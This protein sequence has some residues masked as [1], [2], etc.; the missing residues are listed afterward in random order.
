MPPEQL[1]PYLCAKWAKENGYYYSSTDDIFVKTAE[2]YGVSTPLADDNTKVLVTR[3][4]ANPVI[5][6]DNRK[7]AMPNPY[8]KRKY[9]PTAKQA[10]AVFLKK[11]TPDNYTPCN[12]ISDNKTLACNDRHDNKTPDNF[13]ITKDRRHCIPQI[14]EIIRQTWNHII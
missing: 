14:T 11:Q 10:A 9:C 4:K 7:T 1:S 13:L 2:G 5:K 8:G 6:I 3:Y 12:S